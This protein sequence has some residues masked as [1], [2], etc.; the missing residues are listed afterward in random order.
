[1]FSFCRWLCHLPIAKKER[2]SLQ[3]S[4][5]SSFT[6]LGID[7]AAETIIEKRGN[8]CF[9]LLIGDKRDREKENLAMKIEASSINNTKSKF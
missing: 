5:N 4:P 7:C 9:G 3:G 1:L 2:K 8:I 6:A